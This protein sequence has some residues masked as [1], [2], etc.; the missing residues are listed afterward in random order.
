MTTKSDPHLLGQ[1]T[2]LGVAVQAI[3]STHPDRAAVA[4]RIHEGIEQCLARSLAQGFPDE[5]V[6]GV[7]STRDVYL[8]R[9]LND[10]GKPRTS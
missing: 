3:L 10:P 6:R 8:L 1:I 4:A 9:R 7:E 2:A 5:F